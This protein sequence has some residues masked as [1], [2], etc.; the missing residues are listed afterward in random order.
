MVNGA[1][2][3][4]G[5]R[6]GKVESSRMAKVAQNFV[7]NMAGTLWSTL[8]GLVA[9]P[10]YLRFIGSE[11]YGLVGFYAVLASLL[12]MLDAGFSAA[13]ARELARTEGLAPEARMDMAGTVRILERMFLLVGT[14]AGAAVVLLAPLAAVH[15]LNVQHLGPESAI[16]SLRL[17][18]LALVLHLPLSLYNGC[19]LGMQRHR[20]MNALS[21]LAATLRAGG[22]V[23]V[24]WLVSPTVEAFFVWQVAVACATFLVTRQVVLRLLPA[25]A[26]SSGAALQRL[27]ALSRFALGMGG[28]NVLGLALTQVDKVVLSFLL[29]LREFG[30]YMVAWTLSS[31][32]YRLSMPLYNSVL[33]RLTQL[34]AQ[35]DAASLRS[36]FLRSGQLMAAL[37]VPF[38]LFLGV[39]SAQILRLWTGNAELADADRYVLAF[40]AAGTMLSGTM[41]VPFATHV[42]FG[43]VRPLFLMNLAAVALLAPLIAFLATRGGIA[44]AAASWMIL[45]AALFVVMFALTRAEL[46]RETVFEWAA[47]SVV[48]PVLVSL[49]ALFAARALLAGYALGDHALFAALAAVGLACEALVI[50]AMPFVRE[51][52][53]SL[54]TGSIERTEPG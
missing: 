17:M 7:A 32:V 53:V 25:P 4:K 34:A 43:R 10:V 35:A 41:Q 22:A 30:Y 33:P 26:R 8:L 39:F 6:K 2:L 15:W 9:V 14:I 51:R 50:L 1:D 52:A 23:L 21:S 31:L 45:N 29:P 20:L 19:L 37:I 44:G 48:L 49:A 28:I 42:A 18:G 5:A 13:A 16:R 47:R 11:G 3:I 40:L 54:L 46:G 12:S 27:R 36:L 38:S 24:L